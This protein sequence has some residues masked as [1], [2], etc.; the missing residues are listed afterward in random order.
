M[1]S[2]EPKREKIDKF[3]AENFHFYIYINHSVLHRCWLNCIG[4]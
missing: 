4:G 2:V 1:L 3:S